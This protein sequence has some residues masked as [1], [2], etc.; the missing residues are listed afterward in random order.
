VILV[1]VVTIIV[2][3]AGLVSAYRNR[4]PKCD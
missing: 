1:T 2:I 3:I 4:P